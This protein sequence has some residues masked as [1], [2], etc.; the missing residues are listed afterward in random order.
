MF[1]LLLFLYKNVTA[2][3]FVMLSFYIFIVQTVIEVLKSFRGSMCLLTKMTVSLVHHKLHVG[4]TNEI[5]HFFKLF[6]FS[7]FKKTYKIQCF[8]LPKNVT[9]LYHTTL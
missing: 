7:L 3:G 8:K 2:G 9:T 1:C 4:P 5:K 6:T